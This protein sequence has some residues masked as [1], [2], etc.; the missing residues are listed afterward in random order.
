[1][2]FMAGAARGVG[3]CFFV[4]LAAANCRAQD[5]APRA[6]II[7]PIH[8]NA[9]TITYAFLDGSIDIPGSVPITGSTATVNIST[10]SFF[11]TFKFFGRSANLTAYLPYGVGNFSGNVGQTGIHAYRSGLLPAVFRFSVNLIGGPAMDTD[12]FKKWRQKTLLGVSIRLVPPTGQYDP[13]KLINYGANRWAFKPELGFSRRRNHW[14]LEIYGG[15]WIFTQN[16]EFFSHNQFSPGTNTQ[17][18]NP[19][20]IFE[21]HLNYDFKPRLWVS[22]DGNF[23]FGGSTSLNGV[24][25]PGTYQQNSR[26]GIS[27]SIPLNKHQALKFSYNRWAQTRYGGNYWS[28]T[29]GWQFGWLGRPN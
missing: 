9:V 24:P 1:M 6:Y 2:K 11:H 22:L 26:I 8:T 5:F 15:A 21:G 10:I 17:S 23:W 19:I 14:I 25:T 29:A 12:E 28:V 3:L 18:Q 13:T 4:C 20:G 16:P 7:T 27:S